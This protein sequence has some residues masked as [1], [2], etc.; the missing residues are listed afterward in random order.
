VIRKCLWFVAAALVFAS[1]P[2]LAADPLHMDGNI[3]RSVDADGGEHRLFLTPAH[4]G[5]GLYIGPD[6]VSKWLKPSA[7][8]SKFHRAAPWPASL[9]V[10]ADRQGS[11]ISEA[12]HSP[13]AGP[14]FTVIERAKAR[15]V[16][17]VEMNRAWTR[18][19]Q[20]GVVLDGHVSAND[21]GHL[22]FV[23]RR[24]NG[25]PT[26]SRAFRVQ[27]SR[28]VPVTVRE[29]ANEMQRGVPPAPA[30]LVVHHDPARPK[31]LFYGGAQHHDHEVHV[32]QGR[33]TLAVPRLPAP[34]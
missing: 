32:H 16:N 1:Q 12:E 34:R 24:A 9:S 28:A 6:G 30:R 29:V 33:A 26:S 3:L 10:R 18:P 23:P 5:W 31:Q 14:T 7:V 27:G 21:E 25:Q 17:A 11:V 19:T 8:I 4:E 2:A 15:Y 22:F 13:Q 20:R